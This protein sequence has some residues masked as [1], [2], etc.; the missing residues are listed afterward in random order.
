MGR[1]EP[2]ERF[3]SIKSD[4]FRATISSLFTTL[5]FRTLES[6]LKLRG[7]YPGRLALS[8]SERKKGEKSAVMRRTARRFAL[9]V[10]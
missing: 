7:T 6:V 2:V 9:R 5:N 8:D 4:P 3:A 1:T 10:H